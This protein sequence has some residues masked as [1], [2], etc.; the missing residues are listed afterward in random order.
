MSFATFVGETGVVPENIRVTIDCG[1]V[2]NQAAMSG[3]IGSITWY[4]NGRAINNGTVF[5]C[6]TVC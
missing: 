2:V 1:L 6:C 4:K 3:E 5:N